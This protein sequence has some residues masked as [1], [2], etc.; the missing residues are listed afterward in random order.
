VVVID[1]WATWCAPCWKT[2]REAQKLFDWATSSG[3]PVTVLTLD[4]MEQFATGE[5][6]RARVLD[7]SKS[8]KFTMP[9][10]LDRGDEAF[11]AFRSPGLPSMVIIAPDGTLFKYHQGLFPNVVETVK[12]DVNRALTG[13]GGPSRAP[14]MGKDI[15]GLGQ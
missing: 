2:L 1:F 9:V 15:I 12:D 3:L 8:Q 14:A 6:R 5:I 13:T 10:L 7:F 4:T 11:K